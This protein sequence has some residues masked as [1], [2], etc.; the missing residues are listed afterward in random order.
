MLCV[1]NAGPGIDPVH[2]PRLFDR[3]YRVDKSRVHLP[4]DGTGLGLA[5]THAIMVAHGG[6]VAVDSTNEKTRFC[7]HFSAS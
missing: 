2:L 5:I 7:L 4:S 3:F 1:E 6:R